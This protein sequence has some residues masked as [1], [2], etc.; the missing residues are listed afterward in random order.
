MGRLTRRLG[1]N[2]SDFIFISSGPA[3]QRLIGRLLPVIRI[4]SFPGCPCLLPMF[5]FGL[6]RHCFQI[7]TV[8][9]R[10]GGGARRCGTGIDEARRGGGF[11]SLNTCLT[12]LRVRIAMARTGRFGVPHV[13][14]VARGAGRFGLAAGHCASIRVHDLVRG[15]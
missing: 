6:I 7:C 1:V 3:R 4:P 15:K 2:L 9:R 12:D 10:S 8:A 13:T 14:R 5:F 11:A